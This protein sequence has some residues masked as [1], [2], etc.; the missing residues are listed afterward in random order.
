M[1]AI[2]SLTAACLIFTAWLAVTGIA[3]AG[4]QLCAT[5]SEAPSRAV[6]E[7]PGRKANTIYIKG[8]PEAR[9]LLRFES[10]CQ[11]S[12]IYRE[13]GA[14]IIQIPLGS[15]FQPG[16]MHVTVRKGCMII[17]VHSEEDNPRH[18]R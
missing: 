4:Q 15:C 5:G 11:K 17:E 1:R 8:L 13:V 12:H 10:V 18:R 14:E 2:G 6:L 3:W 7:L 9:F 16:K